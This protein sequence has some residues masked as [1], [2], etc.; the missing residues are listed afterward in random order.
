[1]LRTTGGKAENCLEALI[2]VDS[3]LNFETVIVAQHTDCGATV[4]RDSEIKQ[5]LKLLAPQLSS[6]IDKLAFRD[7]TG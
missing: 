2:S 1:M 4:F 3:L 7:I 5:K 6:D